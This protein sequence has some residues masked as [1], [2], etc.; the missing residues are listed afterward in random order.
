MP[1]TADDIIADA[2]ITAAAA[3]TQ[4]A[5]AT[6][7]R[8]WLANTA[9]EAIA[10]A[11]TARERA[12]QARDAAAAGDVATAE[13][14]ME[15][16]K[17]ALAQAVSKTTPG[18]VAAGLGDPKDEWKECR[19]TIDRF[20]KLLVDL[21][22]TGFGVV[23]A[24]VGAATFVFTQSSASTKV[25]ILCMLIL[26]IVTLYLID[27]IHQVWLLETVQLASELEVRLG[28][29]L[30]QHLGSEFKGG[31]ATVLGFLLYIV[32]LCATVAIFWISI[33]LRTEGITGGHRMTMLAAFAVGLAAMLAAL[34]W[35]QTFAWVRGCRNWVIA[36][37]LRS[38]LL[39]AAVVAVA[40][41]LINR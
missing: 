9:P 18:A 26:L 29:K 41:W 23:T 25:G 16:A 7:V 27:R 12:D 35:N 3:A 34:N 21:R 28:Y 24:L 39:A 37:P 31:D 13:T 22:K 14:Y 15:A 1:R 19:S 8:E 4:M 40:F 38:I 30:T 36:R 17:A 2:A 20:D 5:A 33:P 11:E 10:A 32:L 6:R